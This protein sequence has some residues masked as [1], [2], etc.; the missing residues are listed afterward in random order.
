MVVLTTE[1]LSAT[2]KKM[3]AM[4]NTTNSVTF[5]VPNGTTINGNTFA[6]GGTYDVTAT[7]TLDSPAYERKTLTWE[8]SLGTEEG[9]VIEA[10]FALKPKLKKR[11]KGDKAE[12]KKALLAAA[13]EKYALDAL[14]KLR[15]PLALDSF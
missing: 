4:A 6:A 1:F 7:Y 3:A 9:K 13:E 8:G 2:E 15:G 14:D 12:F 5:D 10:L 11:F